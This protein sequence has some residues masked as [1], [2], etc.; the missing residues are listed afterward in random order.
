[1]Q[2][3]V[4]YEDFFRYSLPSSR[5][6]VML[7]KLTNDSVTAKNNIKEKGMTEIS[8]SLRFNKTLKV[9]DLCLWDHG[10]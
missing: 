10:T 9:L 7:V 4:Y 6:S 5:G 1:M 2:K 8:N 3:H